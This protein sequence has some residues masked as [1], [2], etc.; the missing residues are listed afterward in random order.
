MFVLSDSLFVTQRLN[1]LNNA[2]HSFFEMHSWIILQNNYR[3]ETF[4][5]DYCS[6]Y[7]EKHKHSGK[8]V[9]FFIFYGTFCE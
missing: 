5:S 3:A 1:G 9:F 2:I 8:V 4:S 6:I 7:K